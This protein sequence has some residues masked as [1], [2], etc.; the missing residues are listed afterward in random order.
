M[1]KPNE[2]EI[3]LIQVSPSHLSNSLVKHINLQSFFFVRIV[4]YYYTLIVYN[5][6]ETK[7]ISA[8]YSTHNK[9]ILDTQNTTRSRERTITKWAKHNNNNNN[10]NNKKKAKQRINIEHL[11]LG[12]DDNLSHLSIFNPIY[13]FFSHNF[14]LVLAKYY[15][16]CSIDLA[17]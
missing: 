11:N 10:N 13:V 8:T 6:R 12:V 3:E 16:A 1:N 9:Y 7:K 15:F 17:C 2:S 14:F 4:C 5:E